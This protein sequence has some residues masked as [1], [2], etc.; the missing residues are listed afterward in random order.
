MMGNILEVENLK[1]DY[2]DFKLNQIN[3]SIPKG[4]IMGL[5]GLNGAGKTTI[6]KL[7]MNLIKK[8]DGTI[9]IFGMD[10]EKESRKIKEKIGFIYDENYYFESLKLMPIKK[11]VSKC[12]TNWD[13]DKF[14]AYIQKFNLPVDRKVKDFSKGMKIKLSL[15]FALSHNP[16]L[17]IMDE[18]T[19]GLDPVFRR[20]FLEILREEAIEDGKTILFST[21]ITNDLEKVADYITFINDG[22]TVFSEERDLI[23]EKYYIVKTKNDSKAIEELKENLIGYRETSFFLEGLTDDYR[24]LKKL[25]GDILIEKAN[26][27]EIMYFYKRGEDNAYLGI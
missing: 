12:Y 1:K 18:P 26:I 19:S 17:I 6:I 21:H 25:D 14:N 22:E 4:Y 27:E 2:G 23:E 10:S 7:I 13:D 3:F 20:E 16:E 24:K 5:V 8:T 11:I 15:A 9:K